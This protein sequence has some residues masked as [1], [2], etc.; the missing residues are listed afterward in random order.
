[1]VRTATFIADPDTPPLGLGER[2][3]RSREGPRE[4]AGGQATGEH[5]GCTIR[6]ATGEWC[7]DLR[8]EEET[9]EARDPVMRGGLWR[10]GAFHCT[11]VAH[12]P[13]SPGT[14]GDN[15][16]FRVVCTVTSGT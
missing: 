2:D 1:M 3:A 14:K 4:T 15:I 7:A 13:G 5:G 11:A 10:S 16:G 12:D 8:T 6:W 9:G